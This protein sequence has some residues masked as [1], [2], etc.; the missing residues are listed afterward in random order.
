[1]GR[2]IIETVIGALVLIVAG[3][4]LAF[5]YQSSGVKKV[6]GYEIQAKFNNVTGLVLGSDVRVGG[7]KVGVVSAMALDDNFQAV[8]KFQIKADTKIPADSTAAVVGDGLLGSKF[9]AI[10]PGGD[11]KM[12]TQ[13]GEIKFVQD[14]V[15]LEQLIGKFM[16]SGGGV[17]G[18]TKQEE[19]KE[20]QV[21]NAPAP[22]NNETPGD[23]GGTGSATVPSIE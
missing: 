20:P 18:E 17:E 12:L 4:F 15:S 2:N 22:A 3:G 23:A 8:T 19:T 14:A 21:E 1:M 5:A 16:F 6:D 13:G 11:D 7:I 10:E 9:V